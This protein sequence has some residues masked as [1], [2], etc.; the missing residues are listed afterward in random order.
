MKTICT[1]LCLAALLCGCA[2]T[3][4]TF[5][6]AATVKIGIPQ[7]FLSGNTNAPAPAR[8]PKDQ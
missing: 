2:G 3:Y 8:S 5:D 7:S 6:R 1:T 4:F